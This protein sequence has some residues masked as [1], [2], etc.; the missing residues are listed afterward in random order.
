MTT[1]TFFFLPGVLSVMIEVN[2]RLY[3]DE[4]FGL[5]KQDYET[6]CAAARLVARS[7]G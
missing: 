7:G 4:H 3:I 1:H 2:R 5:K 6:V